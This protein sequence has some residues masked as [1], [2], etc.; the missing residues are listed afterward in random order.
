MTIF[1][2]SCRL[3]AFHTALHYY[4]TPRVRQTLAYLEFLRTP[5]PRGCP[6]SRRPCSVHTAVRPCAGFTVV[7]SL[8]YLHS[9]RRLTDTGNPGVEK[10]SLNVSSLICGLHILADVPAAS[11]H[12]RFT[13]LFALVQ[14]LLLHYLYLYTPTG[15]RQTRAIREL[16]SLP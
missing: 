13:L 14:A 16:K 6:R 12:A 5:Y 9:S 1:H 10:F 7:L 2:C 8:H 3:I 4:T 11:A 15:G